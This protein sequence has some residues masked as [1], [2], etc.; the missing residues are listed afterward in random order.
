MSSLLSAP[1]SSRPFLTFKI[2]LNNLVQINSNI[3]R[4]NIFFCPFDN[5]CF[6]VLFPMFLEDTI[7]YMSQGYI[8]IFI[9]VI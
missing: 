3:F 4:T 5:P 1:S 6:L 9:S 7:Y 8:S 2:T